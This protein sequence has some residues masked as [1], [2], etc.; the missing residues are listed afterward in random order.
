MRIS[1]IVPTL[2]RLNEFDKFLLSI[3][4]NESELIK[5]KLLEVLVVDQNDDGFGLRHLTTKHS[6]VLNV[7]YVTSSR[8]GLSYNRNV[9]LSLVSLGIVAFPDDDCTYYSDTISQ[10]ESFFLNNPKVDVVIGRIFDRSTQQNIIRRWPEEEVIVTKFN[11]YQVSSSITI[12]LRE[13][14]DLIFD[15]NL[16]AGAAFGSCEDPDFLYRLLKQG[17]S[18]VYTPNIEVW[19]PT[20]DEST[21]SLEKVNA[22]SSGFGAFVRKEFDLV[23]LYLLLG[24]LVKKS[25]Q[26][27]FFNKNFKKGYFKA[28]FTG[29]FK[30]VVKFNRYENK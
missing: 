17:K 28:F 7:N 4:Q 8:K 24:C 20:P 22:Y 26:F 15:E 11:F 13:K 25:F 27:I 9:G 30:G 6:D 14:P 12:F 23:K 29:L 21:I 5:N 18:I 19:H 2:G 16:G 1:L 10:V 3:I